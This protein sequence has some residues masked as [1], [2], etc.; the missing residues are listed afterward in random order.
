MRRNNDCAIPRWRVV[1]TL[2]CTS[3]P[4]LRRKRL[5]QATR[6]ISPLFPLEIGLLEG[7]VRVGKLTVSMHDNKDAPGFILPLPFKDPIYAAVLHYW[8]HK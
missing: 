5:T 3:D 2:L 6:A 8:R 7:C 4:G 1:F